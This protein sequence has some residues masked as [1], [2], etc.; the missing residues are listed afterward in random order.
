MKFTWDETKRQ[1]NQ[2]KHRLDFAEAEIV[3]LGVTFTFEDDRFEYGEYRFITIGM[4]HSAVVVIAH[5]ELEDLVRV[6]S[7]RRATRYER[8][9]YFRGFSEGY[10]EG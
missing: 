9:L 6:I 3:F 4:L 2:Q 1:A 7:M 10:G 5:T 8:T